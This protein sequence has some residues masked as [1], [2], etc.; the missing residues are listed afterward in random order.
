ME[1]TYYKDK[2]KAYTIKLDRVKDGKYID[3]LDSVV[4]VPALLR[5]LIDFYEEHKREVTSDGAAIHS[6]ND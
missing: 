5:I 3:F 6:Q 1:Y 4:S 2:Y